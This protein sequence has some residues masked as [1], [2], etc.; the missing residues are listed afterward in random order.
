MELY[1]KA[2]HYDRSEGMLAY[3]RY[4][5]TMVNLS[6]HWGVSLE[7]TVAVFVSLS[8]N[9][10]Y[11]SNLRSTASVLEAVHDGRPVSTIQVATYRHCLLRAY[12]YA[13]DERDFLTET[14]GKKVR[15]FYLNVLNPLDPEPVT[16][17]G[18]MVGAWRGQA[19]TMKQAI[20]RSRE[21]DQ[22]ADAI[23]LMASALGVLPNQVQATLWFARKRVL[24]VLYK[25]QLDLFA[26][27][28]AWRT[29]QTAIDVPP[30][31]AR[32]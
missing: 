21:Y 15:S 30:Y 3:R 32:H 7:K 26:C 10:N 28:D 12:A 5:S 16:V 17:D 19:L 24:G 27:G 4:H 8:P 20:P 1:V 13:T 18:H 11:W 6:L 31:S 25:P 2:D 29:E 22:I 9:N 14:K 23:R